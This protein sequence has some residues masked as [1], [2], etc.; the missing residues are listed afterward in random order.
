VVTDVAYPLDLIDGH[1]AA[2]AV[3]TGQSAQS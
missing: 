1:M 2:A 3:S